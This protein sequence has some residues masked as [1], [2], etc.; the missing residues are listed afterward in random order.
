MPFKS[1]SQQRYAFGTH[2]PWASEFA[3][4]TPNF[5]GSRRR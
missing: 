4:S 1:K 5:K 2:Q 3:K